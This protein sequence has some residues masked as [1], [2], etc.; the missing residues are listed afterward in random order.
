MANVWIIFIFL[1]TF[2][3]TTQ[4][5]IKLLRKAQNVFVDA[6]SVNKIEKPIFLIF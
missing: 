3:I 1:N 6:M 2:S 5:I 4:K